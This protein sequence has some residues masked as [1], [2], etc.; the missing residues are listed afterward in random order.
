MEGGR[1]VVA[2][3]L[4]YLYGWGW[5]WD[6]EGRRVARVR[7]GRRGWREEKKAIV[8]PVVLPECNVSTTVLL[9]AVKED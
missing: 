4:L 5:D 8:N 7:M 3:P 1:L 6:W 9:N 2:A